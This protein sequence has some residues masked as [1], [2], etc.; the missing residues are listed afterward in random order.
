MYSFALDSQ[1]FDMLK[2]SFEQ[3][4]VLFV[5]NKFFLNNVLKNKPFLLYILD[6]IYCTVCLKT[7]GF[8]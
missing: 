5:H 2:N 7:V 4:N 3:I 6:Q 1:M 8:L